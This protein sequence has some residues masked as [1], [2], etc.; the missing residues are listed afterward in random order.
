MQPNGERIFSTIAMPTDTNVNGDIFGGWLLSQMDLAGGVFCRKLAPTRF[1]T[2]AIN[3]MTFLVPV[4]VGDT[5]HCYVSKDSIGRTSITTHIEVWADRFDEPAF[6]KVTEG[7]FIYVAIGED[8][9][10]CPVVLHPGMDK[11]AL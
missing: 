1:V 4:H 6:E 11:D 5:V 10:A 9:K 8:R 3:A 7:T 2:V